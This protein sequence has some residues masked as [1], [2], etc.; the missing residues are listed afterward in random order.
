MFFDIHSHIL[1]GVDD[2]AKDLDESIAL[3]EDIYSQGITD[4]IATP[5]FYPQTDI[6]ED[7]VTNV[8]SRFLELKN[9]KEL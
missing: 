3:L 1:H 8:S 5:H 9:K 2:G 7:F 6:L 4:V